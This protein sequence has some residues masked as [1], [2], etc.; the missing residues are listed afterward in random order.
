MTIT[1][2][3]HS[4]G[5]GR[6]RDMQRSPKPAPVG[7][8][9]GAVAAGGRGAVR[10]GGVGGTARAGTAAG[11]RRR[12]PRVVGQRQ[13]RVGLRLSQDEAEELQQAAD[14]TGLTLSGYAAAAA[15]AVAS[16]TAAP[17]AVPAADRQTR[18]LLGALVAGRFELAKVGN[19]LNQIA[20]AANFDG[21]V[22]P[23][24]LR[25]VLARVEAGV[26]LLDARTVW[27]VNGGHEGES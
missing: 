19:N 16:R 14:R 1:G 17:R 3:E 11:R 4:A 23:A 21:A 15:L 2:G 13:V 27:L 6:R 5:F 12:G 20:R 8:G 18:E 26:R 22:L 7:A 24:Q 10:P 25:E 9:S